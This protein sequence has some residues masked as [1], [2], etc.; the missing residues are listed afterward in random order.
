MPQTGL[1]FRALIASPSDC[2]QERKI[3]PE[4]IA[5]WNAVHS[6]DCGAI[7]EPVLWETHSRPAFGDR[8]QEVINQQL[9]ESCDLV[10]GAFW[11]KLGTPTGNAES[12]TAEEI[13]QFRSSG[14]PVLLYF[15]S[16]PAVPESVD[17]DQYDA[18]I[19]YRDRLGESG[20]YS[21]YDSLAGFR[22]QL[23]RHFAS[24]MIE[25][26]AKDDS[27]SRMSSVTKS[28]EQLN[29]QL[30]QIAEFLSQYETFLRR[31]DAEWEAERDSN[32]YSTD[33]AKYLLDRASDEI[34]HFKSMITQDGTGI[35]AGLS[36][37]LKKLRELQR[38]QVYLDGGASFAAFWKSGNSVIEE[39]H[40][41]AE[42]LNELLKEAQQKAQGRAE[43]RP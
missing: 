23:Q 20:L 26:L 13:E 1:I 8:P 41:L 16:A 40:P 32:P 36:N 18:L 7:V 3:I 31:L 35:S 17:R 33:D 9:V 19:E 43:A 2:A 22:E 38:H 5:A 29:P 10:I 42:K 39:L 6:I 34:V 24:Q 11:T 4:V 28:Q 27:V 12:G 30:Q 14:K 21:R 15:S 25:L 37:A